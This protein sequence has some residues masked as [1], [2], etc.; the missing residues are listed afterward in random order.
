VCVL[1]ISRFSSAGLFISL[2]MALQSRPL[3]HTMPESDEEVQQEVKKKLGIVPCLWQ[4]HIVHKVLEQ[5]DVI[6]VAPTGMGKSLTYLVPL[7]FVKNGIVLVTP[8]KLLGQ[9]FVNIFAENI[10]S[11]VSMTAHMQY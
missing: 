8:L 6:T 9:Q 3:K 5:D 4:I 11:A 7:V 1:L 2:G 10:I